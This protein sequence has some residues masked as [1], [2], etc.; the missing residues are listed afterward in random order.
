[1]KTLL[2]V[3]IILIGLCGEALSMGHPH[4]MFAARKLMRAKTSASVAKPR[5]RPATYS[6]WQSAVEQAELSRRVL[7]TLSR[8]RP[9]RTY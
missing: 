6:C 8:L 9:T 4:N 2:L 3:G 7:V 1:M 5:T